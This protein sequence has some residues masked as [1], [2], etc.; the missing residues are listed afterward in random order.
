MNAL[1]RLCNSPSPNVVKF[2]GS[3][4]QHGS[5]TLILEYVDN[6]NLA[7]FFKGVDP[8]STSEQVALFW[9]SLFQVFDGLDRIHQLMLYDDGDLVKG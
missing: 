7:T 9:K 8:P 1:K 2:Y 3:F 4:R 5:Y 6:G